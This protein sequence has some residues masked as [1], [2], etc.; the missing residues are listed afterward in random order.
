MLVLRLLVCPCLVCALGC[1]EPLSRA[2]SFLV[3]HPSRLSLSPLVS[4]FS[5]LSRLSWR[6]FAPGVCVP[7]HP[8]P[9][10]RRRD[11]L[12]A[13]ARRRVER[14]RTRRG[15]GVWR[16]AVIWLW[17]LLTWNAQCGIEIARLTCNACVCLHGCVFFF[18]SRWAAGSACAPWRA[19]P[20]AGATSRPAGR[21]THG[22]PTLHRP[23]RKLSHAA[24]SCT[25]SVCF[26][27]APCSLSLYI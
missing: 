13:A 20:R 10:R 2:L 22:R 26:T 21:R 1:F 6:D 7:D 17:A 25:K 18:A 3:D 11:A 24:E 23:S 27:R 15:R 4:Y 5:F 19:A 9:R 12:P 14:R 8:R 16:C